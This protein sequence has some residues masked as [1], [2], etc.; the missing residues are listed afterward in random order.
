MLY[1]TS[2][3]MV[4]DDS[5]SVAIRH[6]SKIPNEIPV[7]H[8]LLWNGLTPIKGWLK[9]QPTYYDDSVPISTPSLLWPKVKHGQLLA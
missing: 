2:G 9:F 7:V 5:L 3:M 4:E 1:T 6:G 8:N